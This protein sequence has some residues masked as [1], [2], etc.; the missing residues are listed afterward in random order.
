MTPFYK[1]TKSSG[2]QES[3]IVHLGQ[4]GGGPGKMEKLGGKNPDRG[5]RKSSLGL[6]RGNYEWKEIFN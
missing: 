4:G 6:L 1:E 3:S 5:R 2:K